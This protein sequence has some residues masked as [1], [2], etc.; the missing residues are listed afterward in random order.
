[1]ILTEDAL[2]ERI[3]AIINQSIITKDLD[4]KNCFQVTALDHKSDLEGGLE[5]RLGHSVAL[6][7]F[8]TEFSLLVQKRVYGLLTANPSYP[9]NV[10]AHRI[11]YSHFYENLNEE[12]KSNDFPNRD[13][14]TSSVFLKEIIVRAKENTTLYKNICKHLEKT[15]RLSTDLSNAKMDL[16]NK[17]KFALIGDK[18]VG[19]TAYVNYLLSGQIA[20]FDKDNVIMVRIDLTKPYLETGFPQ[21]PRWQFCDILFRYY[22]GKKLG[23]DLSIENEV[24]MKRLARYFAKSNM[25]ELQ[26]KYSEIRS[27]VMGA[28]IPV[29][30]DEWFYKGIFD[31]LALDK[32]IGFVFVYDGLDRLGLTPD[33]KKEFAVKTNAIKGSILH[34]NADLAAYVISMRWATF[35]ELVHVDPYRKLIPKQ[36]EN[37]PTHQIH[38]HKVELLKNRHLFDG[39]SYPNVYSIEESTFRNYSE[40]LANAFL[41]FVAYSLNISLTGEGKQLSIE[42]GFSFLEKIFGSDKRGMFDALA[43]LLDHFFNNLPEDK[44]ESL[45]NQAA[46]HDL[47]ESVKQERL[48]NIH[49]ELQKHLPEL[50][51]RAYMVIEGLMI[52]PYIYHFSDYKYNFSIDKKGNIIVFRSN[53]NRYR[54]EVFLNIFKY[55]YSRGRSEVV[56]SLAGLRILQYV[57]FHEDASIFQMSI[58]LNEYFGYP[59]Y[60]LNALIEDMQYGGL[61]KQPSVITYVPDDEVKLTNKG[62]FLLNNLCS[63]IEYLGAVVETSPIPSNLV[64]FGAFPISP[65]N[66]SADYVINNKIICAIN[67]IRLLMDIEKNENTRFDQ[68]A[69]KNNL[70]FRFNNY[71]NKTFMLTKNIKLGI[72]GGIERIIHDIFEHNRD[73][74]K[75]GIE[76]KLFDNYSHYF[77]GVSF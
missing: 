15:E 62:S 75:K 42:E 58:F 50:Y 67:F 20:E 19:K 28:I 65:Y 63:T 25:L 27:K 41:Q 49:I 61:L 51:S 18:G 70:A 17:S 9:A 29:K 31:Y 35:H 12:N 26:L 53:A 45:L 77:P 37:V 64:K 3:K 39:S 23:I 66:K 11:G 69:N 76:E 8:R 30:F 57:N 24:L 46:N 54:P 33:S 7:N 68:I 32:N 13:P 40:E 59:K 38:K 74:L 1:M 56:C 10:E 43:S 47:A 73:Y 44:F 2:K 52:G 60:L 48:K 71:H 4:L 16:V 55:P 34:E 6:D 14:D 22:D 36:I 21:W 72:V 5:N